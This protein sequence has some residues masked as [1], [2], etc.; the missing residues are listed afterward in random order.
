MVSG[1]E[2]YKATEGHTYSTIERNV[3]FL[4]SAKSW[5]LE[6]TTVDAPAT[7]RIECFANAMAINNIFVEH[8]RGDLPEE[9]SIA[10][11]NLFTGINNNLRKASRSLSTNPRKAV[12]VLESIGAYTF[13]INVLTPPDKK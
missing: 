9:E 5:V 11:I 4:G 2:L 8:L 1:I 10:L 7:R 13:L 3:Q 12:N 6:G